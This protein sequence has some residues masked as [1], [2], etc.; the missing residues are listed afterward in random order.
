MRLPHL[1]PEELD[2]EQQELYARITG[3]PRAGQRAVVPVTDDAGRLEGP[4]NAL[5]F[6]PRVGAAVQDVGR[7]LRYEGVLDD[8]CREIAILAVA[9][10]RRSAYEWDAHARLGAVAGLRD[11]EIE[12]L[13]R[14]DP[15]VF[16]DAERIAAELAD[17]L[18]HDDVVSD[19]VYSRA[20]QAL[21]TA[22]IV[23]VTVLVGYYRLLAQQLELFRVPAPPG[24]WER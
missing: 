16:T 23:E 6:N 9:A 22:G 10:A 12:A 5:L 2:A 3:G 15:L 13:A 11:D 21:G 20:E 18:A 1:R 4:F 8:R 14:R 7:V 24:P 17:A 19:D